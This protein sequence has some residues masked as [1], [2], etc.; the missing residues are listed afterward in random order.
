MAGNVRRE[1]TTLEALRIIRSVVAASMENWCQSA[2]ANA[3]ANVRSLGA[4]LHATGKRQNVI[5]VPERN[6]AR[7]AMQKMA[8]RFLLVA[9]ACVSVKQVGAA[10]LVISRSAKTGLS[11]TVIVDYQ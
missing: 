1:A 3:N 2:V 9:S 10:Q 7:N 4:V 8:N 6:R 11:M 5:L